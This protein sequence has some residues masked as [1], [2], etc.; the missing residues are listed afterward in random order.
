MAIKFKDI[1]LINTA[2]SINLVVNFSNDRHHMVSISRNCSVYAVIGHLYNLFINIRE[3][4]LLRDDDV[5][6]VK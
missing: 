6:D 2:H 3:D 5:H 1:E 4:K